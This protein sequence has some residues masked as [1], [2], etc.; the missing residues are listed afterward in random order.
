M[1]ESGLW[2]AILSVGIFV[3]CFM[4]LVVVRKANGA[5]IGGSRASRLGAQGFSAVMRAAGGQQVKDGFL[6]ARDGE[7]YRFQL[8]SNS[9]GPD[10]IRASRVLSPSLVSGAYPELPVM[11]LREEND[12][13]RLGKTLGLNR[14]LQTGDSLF[15]ARIY[16]ECDAPRGVGSAVLSSPE[17][18]QGV[19]G[20]L[21]LGYREV[22]LRRYGATL[23]AS[24]RVGVREF[25][26]ET[27]QQT[28]ER[29]ALIGD[30][31]PAFRKTPTS[32]PWPMGKWVVLVASVLTGVMYWCA[33]IADKN[34]EPIGSGLDLMTAQLAF[35]LLLLYSAVVWALLRG[36]S[37]ALRYL[38][39]SII[40][41]VLMAAMIS[42]AVLVTYNG[43]GDTNISTHERVLDHKRKVES[44]D[45]TSYYFY[46]ATVPGVEDSSI[47]LR[48]SSRQF[49]A[50]S[51]GDTFLLTVG[52]GKLGTPW[53]LELEHQAQ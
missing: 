5:P 43:S 3:F 23:V 24:W 18:R 36:H 13:D 6:I 40:V 25:S 7:T 14:E 41:G 21:A 8:K 20:L 9:E 48:V 42:R 38:S 29:L 47:R 30:H 12:R 37:L 49:R 39:L 1:M 53:L 32:T 16:V 15:D 26:A 35:L 10:V 19:T 11:R 27:I 31:L 44:D 22:C 46:F 52:A 2:L 50:A 17:V 4:T 34:W 51:Q 45:S 33:L 28:I